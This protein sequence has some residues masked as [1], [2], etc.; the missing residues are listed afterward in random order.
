MP[1]RALQACAEPGCPELVIN[2]YCEKHQSK[3]NAERY[4]QE[5][6]TWQY[7][8]DTARWKKIRKAQLAKEPWCRN[9]LENMGEYVPATQCDHI[10]PHRG[11]VEKFF[12]GPF[13]SLCDSC[14]SQKTAI[15]IHGRGGE[16]STGWRATSG[17]GG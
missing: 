17:S 4:A 16:K 10:E 5:Q 8:Y 2:G 3:R 6:R 14:H 1:H 15:E 12:T 13:Q 9:H 11:D 7:L